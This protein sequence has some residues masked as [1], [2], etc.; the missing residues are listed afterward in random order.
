MNRWS[1]VSEINNECETEQDDAA[2]AQTPTLDIA[3]PMPA[4][5][6]PCPDCE[7]SCSLRAESCPSCGCVLREVRRIVIVERTGWVSTIAYGIIWAA[8]LPWIVLIAV[9]LFFV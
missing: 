7:H 6:A 2:I 3:Q 5:L 4:G 8:V 1:S 9:I